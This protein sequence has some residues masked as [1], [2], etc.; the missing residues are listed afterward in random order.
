ML[1]LWHKA[2]QTMLDRGYSTELE[3]AQDNLWI[4]KQINN[5]G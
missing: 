3:V 2:Q 4:K 5:A 1:E